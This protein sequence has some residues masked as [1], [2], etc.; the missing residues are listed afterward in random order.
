M[1]GLDLLLAQ[2]AGDNVAWANQTSV[3]PVGLAV[4][5]VLGV[6]VFA[7]PRAW[8]LGPLLVLACFVPAG[9]RIVLLSMDFSFLRLLVIAYWIRILAFQDYKGVRLTALDWCVVAWILVGSLVY[10]LQ[11]SNMGAVTNRAGYIYES[12]GVYVTFRCLLRSWKDIERAVQIFAVLSIPVVFFFLFER[13]TGRNMF[14]VMGGVPQFTM[15]RQGRMRAQGAFTHPIMAGCF[16]AIVMVLASGYFMAGKQR[17]TMIAGSIAAGLIVVACAS[18]TPVLAVLSGGLAMGVAFIR[19]MLWQIRIGVVVMLFLLHLVMEAPVWHLIA[20]V[21]AVGGSTGWHRFH[22]IDRTIANF[23]EWAVLGTRSTVHWGYGLQDVTNQYI[24]EGVR[25]GF[26]GMALFVT[27]IVLAFRAV[28]RA[29]A[30]E[31]DRGGYF[32]IKWAV[33]ASLFTHCMCFI[34]VSY[35]GQTT[36]AWFLSIAL[37]AT[38]AQLPSTRPRTVQRVAPSTDPQAAGRLPVPPRRP[39]LGPAQRGRLAHRAKGPRR[40]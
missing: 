22:L 38:V 19:T 13:S 2:V 20:R 16:F 39:A 30:S 28:G 26:V 37:A 4:L 27:V 3:H 14:S 7:L 9:Q 17:M 34:G 24:L 5:L 21:S 40:A 15:E 12:L 31:P 23:T 1:M 33:G 32:W 35:F 10:M 29:L 11:W 36:V 6:L 8:S 25:G 18:S